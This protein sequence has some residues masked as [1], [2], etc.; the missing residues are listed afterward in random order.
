MTIKEFFGRLFG[1]WKGIAQE[2]VV[3][4]G[5]ICAQHPEY[6]PQQRSAAAIDLAKQYVAQRNP[7]YAWAIPLIV[8]Y[9]LAQYQ[10]RKK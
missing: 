5:L 8:D 2:L 4:F 1:S 10:A 3:P 7:S 9:L 6:T